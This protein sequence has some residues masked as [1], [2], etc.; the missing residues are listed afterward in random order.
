M[1]LDEVKMGQVIANLLVNAVKFSPDR[2]TIWVNTSREPKFVK[3]EVRDQGP[4][5]QPE[6]AVQIFELFGQAVNANEAR[7]GGLGIGLHLVKRITELHGGHVGVNSLPGQ[8]SQFWIR[9]PVALA[10]AEEDVLQ[11]AA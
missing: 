1:R 3:I 10:Q 2:G 9:L 7:G 8:G 6:D 11:S 4:G 5:I